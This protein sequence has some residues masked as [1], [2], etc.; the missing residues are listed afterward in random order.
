MPLREK[1]FHLPGLLQK[2]GSHRAVN[3]AVRTASSP[4]K[5]SGH[6]SLSNIGALPEPSALMMRSTACCEQLN[7]I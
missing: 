2:M 1:G 5:I 7:N 3:T 6:I 4:L